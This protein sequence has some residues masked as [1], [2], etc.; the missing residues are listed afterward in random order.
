MELSE[1][2][3]QLILR[4]ADNG[5][6]IRPSDLDAPASLGLLGMRERAEL[7]GGE[8]TFQPGVACGTLVTLRVPMT[9]ETSPT[10]PSA[11]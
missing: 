2:N 6:G 5:K 10:T 4:V 3:G 1:E 8:V 9:K 7:L 11:A